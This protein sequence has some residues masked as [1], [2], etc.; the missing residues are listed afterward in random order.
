MLNPNKIVEKSADPFPYLII[1]DFFK[2]DFYEEL[3]KEFQKK[4]SL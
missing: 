2:K 1:K 3:E 4:K